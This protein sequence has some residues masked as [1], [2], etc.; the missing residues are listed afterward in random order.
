MTHTGD[1]V[2]VAF[3]RLC[4]RFNT[5]YALKASLLLRSSDREFVEQLTMPQPCHYHSA[6][7]FRKDYLIY[8][9]LRKYVGLKS[10]VDTEQVALAK[11]ESAEEQTRETNR[12]LRE[13]VYLGYQTETA[14]MRARLKIASLLGRFSFAKVLGGCGMGPGATFDMSRR[15]RPGIKYSLPISVTG[16]ALHL[17]KAWLEHDVH[18]F[19]SGTGCMPVGPYSV[20]NNRNTF[21]VVDG[22]KL[23][24]VP[25]DSSTD[26]VICIE[27]TFNLFFQK[28]V[29]S[30]I[31]R[32]LAKSGVDLNDQFR[33]QY[34]AH[35]A[36]D[37]GFATIDLSSASDTISI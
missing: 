8:N 31:R 34:L 16:S 23:T 32:Q 33:N 36:Y 1:S 5:P 21:I 27:P 10:G 6:D 37:R 12:K 35:K 30:Y 18:W 24:T 9:Y 29:G 22:N 7:E 19:S 25:K 2:R 17:A 11:W 28:G 15:A 3:Q 26:R 20:I 14:I 4:A 13:G